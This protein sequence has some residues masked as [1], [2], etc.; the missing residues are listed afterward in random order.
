MP[1]Q[2]SRLKFSANKYVTQV[3]EVY[4]TALT[5]II[6]AHKCICPGQGDCGKQFMFDKR[7]LQIW[8]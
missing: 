2:I 7:Q 5:N 1:S 8:I 4:Q 3:E 6:S